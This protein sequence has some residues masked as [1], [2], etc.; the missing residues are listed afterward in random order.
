MRREDEAE[1]AEA[2]IFGQSKRG[3]VRMK[4]IANSEAIIGA[5]GLKTRHRSRGVIRAG[6][7]AYSSHPPTWNRLPGEPPMHSVL[8]AAAILPARTSIKRQSHNSVNLSIRVAVAVERFRCYSSAS[9]IFS[10][11]RRGKFGC[12]TGSVIGL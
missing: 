11:V 9:A 8:S 4:M 10:A 6:H 5:G 3:H 12:S 1:G 7:P 2:T